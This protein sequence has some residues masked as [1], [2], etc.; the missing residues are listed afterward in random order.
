[1]GHSD[2]L[3]R[4]GFGKDQA[5]EMVEVMTAIVA[6]AVN[7]R[8]DALD[9]HLSNVSKD[10]THK[11]ELTGVELKAHVADKVSGVY[12]RIAGIAGGVAV[13]SSGITLLVTHLIK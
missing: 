10:V 1:M 9:H 5:D 11:I 3:V 2:R 12:L 7:K 4:A 13:A 6:D 8:F